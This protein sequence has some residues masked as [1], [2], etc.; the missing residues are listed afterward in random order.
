MKGRV[1]ILFFAIIFI[2]IFASSGKLVP[3]S[4]TIK[5]AADCILGSSGDINCDN[6]VDGI[7]FAIWLNHYGQSISPAP[8]SAAT[9]TPRPSATPTSPT[10]GGTYPAQILDLATW[11]VQLPILTTCSIDIFQPELA[12]YKIDPW[13][14]T[15]PGGGVQFRAAVNGKT[16]PN[17]SY[18]RSELREML[19]TTS[20]TPSSCDSNQYAAWSSTSGT[21][22][23]TVDEKVTT[24]PTG[25]PNIVIAQIHDANDDVSVFRVEGTS[26]WIT[27]GNTSHGY[28]VDSNFTLNKRVTLKFEVSGGKIKYYYNG[29]LVPYTQ[30]KSFSGAYFKAGAYV[31][32]N[33]GNASPCS[34][35]NYGEVVM[36]SVAVTH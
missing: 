1:F 29:Q 14:T 7:D 31:Q 33:C 27:D 11:K 35:S 13:F 5:A 8:T 20:P 18:A 12:T 34:D 6:K 9:G 36:Y 4:R 22:T 10:S 16:T 26:L 23:L 19:Y 32:A 2:G 24:L 25:R 3:L 21:H 15:A 30:S 28:L 17:S